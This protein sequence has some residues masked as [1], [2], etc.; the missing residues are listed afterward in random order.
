MFQEVT[1]LIEVG[2]VKKILALTI[3]AL[4]VF[5]AATPAM[6][7]PGYTLTILVKDRAGTA[8]AGASIVLYD[9]SLKQVASGITNSSGYVEFTDIDNGT[10]IAYLSWGSNRTFTT[11]TVAGDTSATIDL[12]AIFRANVTIDAPITDIEYTVEFLYNETVILKKT[13]KGNALIYSSKNLNITFP[14]EVAKFPYKY[15]FKNVTYDGSVSEANEISLT[16]SKDYEV[17]PLY[18]R[19]WYVAIE[20]WVAALLLLVIVGG[21]VFALYFAGK[22]AKKTLIKHR[23]REFRFV[24]REEEE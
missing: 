13:V 18:E 6:A 7:A 17:K 10:Y 24:K 14:K 15:V 3:L 21:I 11:I 1:Y 23:V 16:M 5:L 4:V 9:L 2:K 19:T 22:A 8:V 20:P 12:S